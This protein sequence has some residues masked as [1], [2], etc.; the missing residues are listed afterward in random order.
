MS[1][2]HAHGHTGQRVSS[3]RLFLTM[4][5]NFAIT[6]AEV[7]GGLVS[8]SL[9]LISDALHNLSDGFAIII[10]YIAIRLNQRPKSLQYTFGLKRA[11]ILAAIVNASTLIIICFF[12][13]KEAYSRLVSPSA[14][15]GGVM[16]GVAAIGLLANVIGTLLLRSGAKESMNI[17]AAYLHLFSDAL[18]S[19]AVIL[20]GLAITLFHI[21]WLDPV[22]TI[23]ISLYVLKASFAIVRDAVNMILMGSPENLS[24]RAIQRELEAIPG[25]RNIHHVHVWRLDEHNIHFE[26]HVEVEDMRISETSELLKK[27]EDLLRHRFHITHVTLQFESDICKK[28]QLV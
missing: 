12:L 9:S 13:F 24:L 17:R 18:S 6:I 23:L 19:V 22:L 25:V 8:G 2:S 1:H 11:E 21:Y 15:S 4:A 7:I 28:K 3:G 26:A 27:M 20:G 16:A 14:V 10:S 5:L